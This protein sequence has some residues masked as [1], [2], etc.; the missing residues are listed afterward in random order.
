[1]S[2][3]SLTSEA[4]VQRSA[5]S[6]SDIPHISTSGTDIPTESAEEIRKSISMDTGETETLTK[7]FSSSSFKRRSV[8]RRSSK[9]LSRP[10]PEYGHDTETY[11]KIRERVLQERAVTNAIDALQERWRMIMYMYDDLVDLNE[12]R[13]SRKLKKLCIQRQ[14]EL[15]LIVAA[16]VLICLPISITIA[17]L[18]R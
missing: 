16:F 11:E 1:M 8:R 2:E 4:T 9:R 13:R 17:L 12:E 7:S 3:P 18:A 5:S 10:E 14:F 6:A 15:I